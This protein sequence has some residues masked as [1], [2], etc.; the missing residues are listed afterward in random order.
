MMAVENGRMK[1]RFIML[2]ALFSIT[3]VAVAEDRGTFNYADYAYV[4]GHFV[5]EN[6]MVDYKRLKKSRDRLDSFT[7]NFAK[8]DKKVYKSWNEKDRIAFW[9]NAYNALTLKA[10]IDHYP[11]K[12]SLFGA[13]KYPKNSIKQISGV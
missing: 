5:D 9:I 11:I 13:I 7:R 6:G 1:M 2:L 3:G 12:A 4:L 10:I 8:L